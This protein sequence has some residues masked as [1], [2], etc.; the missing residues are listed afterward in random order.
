MNVQEIM[1]K[2]VATCTPNDNVA[3]AVNVRATAS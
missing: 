1:K 3:T 2:D